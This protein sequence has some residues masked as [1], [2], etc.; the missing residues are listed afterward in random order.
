MEDQVA[1]MKRNGEKRVVALNSFLSYSEKNRIMEELETY[2]FIFISPEMLLQTN[3]SAKLK[4]IHLS[5]IVVDEA[6]CIS[7][8]GF[9]FRPDYLRIGEFLE[10]PNRPSIL[11]LTATADDKVIE[12]ISLF[13]SSKTHQFINIH[14]TVQIFRFQLVRWNLRMKKRSGLRTSYERRQDLES[15]M[16][17]QENVR[18]N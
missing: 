5:L 2:K 15:F 3:V 4:H 12:D 10:Q 17:H 7:Q 18:M 13:T 16:L 1:I 14:L 9:D 6:H 8:W 11:A